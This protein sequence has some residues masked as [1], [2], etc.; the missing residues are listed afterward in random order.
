VNV[1]RC[2]DLRDHLVDLRIAEA[3]GDGVLSSSER[4]SHRAALASALSNFV[5]SCTSSYTPTQLQ[6]SLD[7][8]DMAAALACANT[9]KETP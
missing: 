4:E 1:E 2:T 5:Q 6:C 9:A 8:H 7:A 3:M